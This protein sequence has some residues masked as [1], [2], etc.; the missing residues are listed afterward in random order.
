MGTATH[1]PEDRR[2]WLSQALKGLRRRRGLRPPDVARRM[3][4]A[5][6][7]F[8]HFE[9]GKGPLNID[10]IHQYARALNADP[11]A[12]LMALEIGSPAFAARCADNKLMTVVTMALQDFDAAT[13]DA[14]CQLDAQTLRSSFERLFGELSDLAKAR[15]ALAERWL[16]GAPPKPT[17]DKADG[18]E[19]SPG[20]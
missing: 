2:G 4:M 13:G 6:R 3:G 12:L 5:L 11:H 19:S 15:A 20:G 18:I 1:E 17:D 7:S 10:R 9:A 8:E 14:I 16:E